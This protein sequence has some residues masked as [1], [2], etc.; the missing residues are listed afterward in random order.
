M[1]RSSNAELSGRHMDSVINGRRKGGKM[2]LYFLF[3]TVFT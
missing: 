2:I 1:E 3:A